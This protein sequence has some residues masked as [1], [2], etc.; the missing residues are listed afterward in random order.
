MENT[1]QKT[2]KTPPWALMFYKML[3][4]VLTIACLFCGVVALRAWIIVQ[5]MKLDGWQNP[6][7][8]EL[9]LSLVMFAIGIAGLASG[10]RIKNCKLSAVRNVASLALLIMAVAFIL[11]SVFAPL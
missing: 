2:N 7:K 11:Y 6:V 1:I 9:T 4:V 10:I 5:K 8:N 3:A